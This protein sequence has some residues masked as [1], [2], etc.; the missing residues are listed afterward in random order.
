MNFP[1]VEN[2]FCCLFY[3]WYSKFQWYA[4][5]WCCNQ[6]EG[7]VFACRIQYFFHCPVALWCPIAECTP[8]PFHGWVFLLL[9]LGFFLIE[10]VLWCSGSASWFDSHSPGRGTRWWQ[11]PWIIWWWWSADYQSLCWQ[12]VPPG[13][14][15][16]QLACVLFTCLNFNSSI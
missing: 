5:L 16:I 4:Q 13:I 3:S 9:V 1:K 15:K 6:V 12:F 8:K 14:L 10:F 7:D 2:N 11:A